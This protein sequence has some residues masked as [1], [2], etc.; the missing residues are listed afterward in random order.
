MIL[1]ILSKEV[2][3]T[4]NCYTVAFTILI[5]KGNSKNNRI[6]KSTL[7]IDTICININYRKET[8]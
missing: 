3:V 7:Y 1:G 6:L 2:K 5:N 8:I 4:S